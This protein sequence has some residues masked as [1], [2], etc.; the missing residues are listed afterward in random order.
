[1]RSVFADGQ[2]QNPQAIMKSI[3]LSPGDRLVSFSA[4]LDASVTY[5]FWNISRANGQNETWLASGT[6][7]GVNWAAPQRLGFEIAT[8]NIES[9]FNSGTVSAARSGSQMVT[10][11]AALPG[12]N[13]PLPVAVTHDKKLG[14]V[15]LQQGTVVG[16][17]DVVAVSALIGLPALRTDRDRFLYLTWS[18]P[19]V[20]MGK[21]DLK[22]TTTRR[23]E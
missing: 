11:A 10:W 6:S 18:E 4:S 14:I 22:L 15:Y 12:Q 2:L 16:Y 19:N 5:L 1:M 7:D 21:A 3:D 23:Y 9:G 8:G 20:T 17:Q 13:D